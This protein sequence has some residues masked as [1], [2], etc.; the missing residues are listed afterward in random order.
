MPLRRPALA[1]AITFVCALAVFTVPRFAW[2]TLH[3]ALGQEPAPAPSVGRPPP[4]A[5][6]P[7]PPAAP[8]SLTQRVS[9]VFA[10]AVILGLGAA[11]TRNRRA[12][13]R[14]VMG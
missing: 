9:G 1:F 14:R 13:R 8:R 6:T 7:A 12:I 5:A 4:P 11:L 3:A 2:N 10:L